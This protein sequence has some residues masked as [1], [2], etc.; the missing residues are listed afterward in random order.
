ML[1][2]PRNRRLAWKRLRA[3]GSRNEDSNSDWLS[4]LVD[5]LR[6]DPYLRLDVNDDFF[7]DGDGAIMLN[8]SR[9][10]MMFRF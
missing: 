5:L 6:F 10:M 8:R 4:R 1:A 3:T 9:M 2:G 7:G